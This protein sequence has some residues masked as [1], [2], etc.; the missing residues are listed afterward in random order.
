[1]SPHPA[2]QHTEHRP[3]PL[4][5]SPWRWR[6]SW[7]E[8]LF[9]HWPVPVEAVRALLPDGLEVDSYQGRTYVGVVPFR[10]EGVTHRGLPD[11]PGASA[12]PELNLRLYVTRQDRPGVWFLSLDAAN[13]LAVIAARTLF[14]LPYF[15]ARMEHVVDGDEVRYRSVRR[16]DPA[17][18]GFSARYRPI[19]PVTAAAPGSLEHWLTERYCLYATGAGGRL[20]RAEVHHPP[21]PLQQAEAHIERNELAEPHGLELPGPPPLLHYAQRMDVVVWPLRPVG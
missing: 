8:L 17:G 16:R 1:V 21:W 15:H 4:P 7:C 12:F 18:L 11:L 13:L 10:M 6:Q 3:W 9:A 20:T 5:G 14:H 2:L 19:G